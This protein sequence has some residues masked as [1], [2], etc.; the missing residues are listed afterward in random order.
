MGPS[1]LLSLLS[2]EAQGNGNLL[3]CVVSPFNTRQAMSIQVNN[4]ESSE[5]FERG[6][7]VYTSTP[8]EQSIKS[9]PKLESVF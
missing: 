4:H 2:L 7:I 1:K 5:T 3:F 8:E 9:T 6:I